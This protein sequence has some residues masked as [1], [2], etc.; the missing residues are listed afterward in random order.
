V[1]GTGHPVAAAKAESRWRVRPPMARVRRDGQLA[2]TVF[3]TVALSA[4]QWAICA[5]A[6]ATVLLVEET[7]RLIN[8]RRSVAPA[9][10]TIPAP[11]RVWAE[12]G[13][14]CRR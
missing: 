9:D 7:V 4:G 13:R 6:A 14:G 1:P 10:T 12:E 8:R 3:G 11:A 5:A 2:E